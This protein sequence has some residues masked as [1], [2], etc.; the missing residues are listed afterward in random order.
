MV[1]CFCKG[2]ELFNNQVKKL[3]EVEHELIEAAKRLL[4]QASDPVTAVIKFLHDRPEN[5]VMNGLEVQQ[6]LI[7]SFEEG[8]R[9]PQLVSLLSGH[10]KQI[11]RHANVIDIVNEHAV[12]DKIGGYIVNLKEH[13]KFEIGNEKGKTVLKNIH[14]MLVVEHGIELPIEKIVINPPKLEVTVKIGLLRP[15]RILDII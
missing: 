13:L 3:T 6:I 2:K 7:E 8:D 14:G 11:I 10:V 1:N 5:K 15:Q 4:K 9:I 12:Q